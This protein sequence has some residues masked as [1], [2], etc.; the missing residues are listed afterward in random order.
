MKVLALNG[1][2]RSEGMSKSKIMLN[3]LVEGMRE[4]GAE[5]DVV[6]LREKKVRTCRGCMRCWTTSP[7]VC[8]IK[9]DMTAELFPKWLEADLAV[10]SFPLYHFTINADMKAFIERTLP[11]LQPF[12]SPWKGDPASAA[13]PASPGCLSLWRAFPNTRSSISS[14]PGSGSCTAASGYQPRSTGPWPRD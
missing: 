11:V 3:A 5:V 4:A 1:S 6:D 2:P 7:G 8:A 13:L 14:R 9:D 12:S 10:Y